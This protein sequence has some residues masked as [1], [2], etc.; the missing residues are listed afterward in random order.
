MSDVNA[1]VIPIKRG[2]KQKPLVGALKPRIHTPLLKGATKSQEVA[3]LAEKIGMPLLPYQ[4]WVLDDMLKIDANGEFIRKTC[5]LLVAR[6]NGKTHLARMLILA[7]LFLWDSKSIIG[8]SSN[9]NMA[10]QTFRDVAYIIEDNDFLA[11][12]I[13]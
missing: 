9:R 10:L 11:N 8:I 4:R 5:A 12:Q 6:Q 3:D 13:S 1:K 7:H 2:A